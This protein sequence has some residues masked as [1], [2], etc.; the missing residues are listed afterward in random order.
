L[1][2][3]SLRILADP[4]TERSDHRPLGRRVERRGRLVEE[5]DAGLD[6]QHPHQRRDLPLAAREVS[7][8]RVQQGGIPPE[9]LEQPLGGGA[10]VAVLG[11][12]GERERPPHLGLDGALGQGR[13][14]LVIDGGAA[15]RHSRRT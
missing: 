1:H 7:A 3:G 9:G 13:L 15:E 5:Q 4:G 10:L 8:R 2:P 12:H 11:V 6:Q 14:R